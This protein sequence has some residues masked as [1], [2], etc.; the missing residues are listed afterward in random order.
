MGAR[1]AGGRFWASWTNAVVRLG[2]VRLRDHD[3]GMARSAV[4]SVRVSPQHPVGLTSI[5]IIGDDFDFTENLR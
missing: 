2:R 5:R 3:E 4:N 1:I